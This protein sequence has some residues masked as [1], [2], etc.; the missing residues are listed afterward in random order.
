MTKSIIVNL[1]IGNRFYRLFQTQN[2]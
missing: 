2:D 1:P